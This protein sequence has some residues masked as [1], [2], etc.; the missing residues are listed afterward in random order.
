ME[1]EKFKK[2][3]A[4]HREFYISDVN[5]FGPKWKVERAYDDLWWRDSEGGWYA[6]GFMSDKELYQHLNGMGLKIWVEFD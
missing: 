1:I 3:I 6:H 5:S 4:A 2:L